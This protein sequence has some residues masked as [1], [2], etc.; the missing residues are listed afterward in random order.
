MTVLPSGISRF[1]PSGST[2]IAI[3]VILKLCQTFAEQKENRSRL[4]SGWGLYRFSASRHRPANVAV[5]VVVNVLVAALLI[6]ENHI[7]W[8]G[9]VQLHRQ[10][11]RNRRFGAK[12][13]PLE[14]R[15]HLILMF[16]SRYHDFPHSDIRSEERREAILRQ[17]PI[18]P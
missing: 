14:A 9:S 15:T 10:K 1:D 11:R 13:R 2:A 5:V 16:N 4:A 17:F 3:G 6:S 7:G 18:S 12:S 8:R